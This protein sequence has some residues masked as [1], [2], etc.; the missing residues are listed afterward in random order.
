MWEF[1]KYLFIKSKNKCT[2]R[3]RS[4]YF[5]DPNVLDCDANEIDYCFYKLSKYSI[6]YY[7]VE[8]DV[9]L[10]KINSRR[11]RCYVTLS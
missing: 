4:E 1:I 11:L 5:I 2:H 10:K 7:A 8:G 3:N 6:K 9:E